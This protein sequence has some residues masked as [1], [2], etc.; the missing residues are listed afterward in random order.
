MY[1]FHAGLAQERRRKPLHLDR[2][3]WCTARSRV[4][5]VGH[6]QIPAAVAEKMRIGGVPYGVGAP[7]MHGLDSDPRV[8]FR[9]DPPTDLARMLREGVL[10]AALL[11]SI[12][13]Y[14]HVG[15]RAAEELC[16]ASRGP[17]RSVRAFIRPGVIHTV[18]MD[19]G[20][21]TS[22]ALLRILLHHGLIGEC[23]EH[24]EYT[25]IQPTLLPDDLPQD[26]VMMI[27]D[28]GLNADPGPRRC[29][30]L[31]ELW[32]GLT[33]LPM[34]YALWLIT[35]KADTDAI[36]P[37][38]HESR[39]ASVE[40]NVSD[41]TDGAIYYSLGDAEHRGLRRFHE[42]AAALDLAETSIRPAFVGI[43][44]Q[45]REDA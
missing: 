41:G 39:R 8:E 33:G 24:I 5:R 12:E 40:A 28:N 45:P 36:I 9:R 38:L 25:A 23:A 13:G 7:L 43:H 15:Y 21:A 27:G 16:I 10:D 42:E 22:V 20:S 30:D 32:S 14:R 11:S 29:A 4:A 26:V 34:V 19:S 1:S 3:L 37:R 18:G 2:A 31:G 44:K 35:A 17:A 6:A